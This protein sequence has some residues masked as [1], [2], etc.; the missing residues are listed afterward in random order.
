MTR[1]LERA[2]FALIET[3]VEVGANRRHPQRADVV[4]WDA[5][6]EGVVRPRLVV[7]V[8]F[9]KQQTIQ[10]AGD[11]QVLA[12]LASYTHA[13][14]ASEGWFFDGNWWRATPSFSHLVQADGPPT[15]LG[16]EVKTI[17]NLEAV[18]RLL[19]H[20]VWQKAAAHRDKGV[21]G[22]SYEN[23]VKIA[24][25]EATVL[26]DVL[27]VRGVELARLVL[28]AIPVDRFLQREA[29]LP[30]E[31]A[32]AMVRLVRPL[33]GQTILNIDAGYGQ[34]LWEILS[35]S[36]T[37]EPPTILALER[38]HSVAEALEGL[39]D[40]SRVEI[41]V[42]VGTVLRTP[43]EDH[44]GHLPALGPADLVLATPPW[45][46]QVLDSHRLASGEHTSDGDLAALDGALRALAPG[47]RC[48]IAMPRGFLV[49]G[50][51]AERFREYISERY[52][53]VA[54]M[55][56]P[57]GVWP[58][59]RVDTALLVIDRSAPKDTLLAE[60]D[61][62]WQSQLSPGGAFL[63]TYLGHTTS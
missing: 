34:V 29:W 19:R 3:E 62:D 35:E 38:S 32:Q 12:Q 33:R 26:R 8:K 42:R 58:H 49:K 36:S 47:G 56:L 48:V 57:S 20:R 37:S 28:D 27:P 16:F 44:S 46:T 55:T 53:V 30:K 10:R 1:D 14:G 60:L 40:L 15:S 7:E 17:S 24:L 50:G 2:G 59:T 23:L 61:A 45:G 41:E 31:L 6:D 4:A 13:L 54:I 25:D 39:A 21:I 63:D 5:D 11:T 22:R 9:R 52:W 51:T 18:H 43:E